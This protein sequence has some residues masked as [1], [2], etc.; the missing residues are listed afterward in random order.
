MQ[1]PHAWVPQVYAVAAETHRI[2]VLRE[3]DQPIAVLVELVEE[4]S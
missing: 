1:T 3:R 2:C 4:V